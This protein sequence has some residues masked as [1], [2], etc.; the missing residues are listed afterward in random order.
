MRVFLLLLVTMLVTAGC[1]KEPKEILIASNPGQAVVKIDQAEIGVTPIKVKVAK[2]IAIDV[3]KL[4]YKPYTATISPSDDP[5][6][7]VTLEKKG[8]AQQN[9]ALLNYPPSES[10]IPKVIANQTYQIA[11]TVTPEGSSGQQF[12]QP[13][14]ILIASEPCNAKVLLNQV[15]RG[16]TPLLL[17]IAKNSVIEVRKTGYQS[18]VNQLSSADAPN[19]IVRL[20]KN[21][22]VAKPKS[23]ISGLNITKLKHMYWQGKINKLDYSARLREL[24]HRMESDLINLK[25]R[26]KRGGINK[27]DYERRAK[28]IK[29]RYKG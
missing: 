5:N 14:E 6:H 17:N 27:Y 9:T 21:Q 11:Q 10:Q 22:S 19:L 25:M 12:E 3:V 29:Y 18:Y 24:E 2:E 23:S 8:L 4:G 13:V 15:D 16:T 26:Y 28:Q 1:D 7:I 20:E